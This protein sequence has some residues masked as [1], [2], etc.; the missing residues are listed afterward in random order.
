MA[1]FFRPTSTTQYND[2]TQAAVAFDNSME[3]FTKEV[4]AYF[5]K[6]N[7]FQNLIKTRE[8]PEGH[9]SAVFEVSGKALGG[10]IFK[11]GDKLEHKGVPHARKNI[12]VDG[13]VVAESWIF[14]LDN[15]LAYWDVR[16]EHAEAL[17]TQ[18]AEAVDRNAFASILK[19]ITETEGLVKNPDN[20]ANI[21]PSRVI[22]LSSVT[23]VSD[24]NTEA[25][26]Q[27]FFRAVRQARTLLRKMNVYDND[28]VL[29]IS[30]AMYE[31][32]FE[33][34]PLIDAD[35][36][37]NGSIA[38]GTLG[39]IFGMKIVE[40]NVFFDGVGNNNDLGEL[41]ATESAAIGEDWSGDGGKDHRVYV[42]NAGLLGVVFTKNAAAMAHGKD[43]SVETEY[44]STEKGTYISADMIAGF[45]SLRPECAVA[46]MGNGGSIS[47]NP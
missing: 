16:R 37:G 11:P 31:K 3:L 15:W 20:S 43:I 10:R 4:L 27:E 38:D 39:R 29:A 24:I 26:V 47:L 12:Q 13:L 25:E 21:L 8:I 6:M 46:I 23:K 19:A 17:G 14:K 28:I 44:L 30:P 42:K 33:Y 9:L 45:D 1:T 40:S 22:N 2:S 7:K 5:Y 41:A 36:K 32:L 18:L 34:L 35:Y